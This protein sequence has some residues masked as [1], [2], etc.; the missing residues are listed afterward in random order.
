MLLLLLKRKGLLERILD[1]LEGVKER[2]FRAFHFLGN[3]IVQSIQR[4]QEPIEDAATAICSF[5]R[6]AIRRRRF[7]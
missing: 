6:I 1:V 3:L 5:S 2:V 7:F 4:V